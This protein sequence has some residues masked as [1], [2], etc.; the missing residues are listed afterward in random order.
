MTYLWHTDI[1][2]GRS[3]FM[4]LFAGSHMFEP[5]SHLMAKMESKIIPQLVA[6]LRIM[7]QEQF[8]VPS[9][10]ILMFV[11]PITWWLHFTG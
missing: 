9:K 3:I 7:V 1:W 4:S 5:L 6:K 11:L 8:W 2:A 10:P